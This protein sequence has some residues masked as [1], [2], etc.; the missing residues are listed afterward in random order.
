MGFV[1]SV[2]VARALGATGRGALA[3][4]GLV[5][6]MALAL[7]T[8]GLPTAYAFFSGK[9]PGDRD[10]WVAAAALSA[11]TIGVPLAVVVGVF[12][13][14]LID[15]W[16]Q[17][18]NTW[19]VWTSAAVIPFAFASFFLS[20]VF[21]G[22]GDVELIAK[23][24]AL[25]GI[26]MSAL[27]VLV[28]VTAEHVLD[29]LIVMALVFNAAMAVAYLLLA[30]RS[31]GF[32]AQGFC[33]AFRESITYG[34][35]A[36]LG[37]VSNQVWLRA[38]AL[39]LNWIAGPAPVGQYSV[40]TSFA[41]RLWLLDTSVG[42]AVT[43]SVIADDLDRAG[44]LA[45]RTARNL[46]LVS[47]SISMAVGVL[48]PFL[49]PLLY[50][51]EFGGAATALVC[52][53]PGT[54]AIAVSRPISTYY[55]GQLGRPGTT[56]AVS[57]LT[58][59]VA[60]TGYVLLIPRYAAIG[61]AV[62]SSIAYSVPL[63]VYC[64]MFP[65]TSGIPLS[66]MLLVQ[67]EDIGL[68]QRAVRGVWNSLRWSARGQG[69]RRDKPADADSPR[70]TTRNIPVG[71][72]KKPDARDLIVLNMARRSPD[73][74]PGTDIIMFTDLKRWAMS[75]AIIRRLF[76]Y[77]SVE[78]RT[79]LYP[80]LG[81]LLPTAMTLRVLTAGP[82]LITD[83]E[84]FQQRV[85]LGFLAG[86][87]WAFLRDVLSRG[88][89][90]RRLTRAVGKLE[91]SPPTRHL[92]LQGT[93]L[94]LRT[95]FAFGIISGGS[96]GHIAG[97]LNNLEHFGGRPVF[98][99]SDDI[100]TVSE[101][102]ESHVVRP[103]PRY[104]DLGELWL[105]S[106]NEPLLEEARSIAGSRT[107]S[108]V[109]QRYS[110]DNFVGLRVA[111]EFQ[112]PF[113]LEYNGS[114]VWI[115][116]N[117]GRPLK[118]EALAEEIELAN[119]HGADLVV[120]VSKAM[121]DELVGRGL[122]PARIL[123]NPNGVD[124]DVYSPEV[125]G[126]AVRQALG[127]DGK[128]VIGFIGTFGRWHGAEVLTEAY[129]LLL[130]KRPEFRDTSRLLMIGDG[131]TMPEVRSAIE[132]YGIRE[133]VVLT[134]LVPQT[135]G[136]AHLAACD[137]LA[138]PHVPNPDGTPFFG[139]PTKLF[140]YMAMGTGIVASDLDQIGEILEH[141]RTAWMVEPGSAQGLADGLEV[142]MSDRQ[143]RERLGAAA[144]AEVI[145]RYTWLEHTRRIIEALEARCAQ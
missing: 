12:G 15:T 129:G 46:L 45:A 38:D 8:F 31:Y 114:E 32:R 108:F 22:A 54:V 95:D 124:P 106:Y 13:S 26:C 90:R 143:L 141:G 78:M 16:L 94:Y 28:V 5:A 131:V 55:S 116:R 39:I 127:L 117:W 67:A 24:Q 101:H 47:G 144:R 80:T 135:Q 48:A 43:P 102:I 68:Y 76:R 133:Q 1:T 72:A 98:V 33:A 89:L 77:R 85:T 23:L 18:L 104:R 36:Y 49:I 136:P 20:N 113:V 35:K 21:L 87:M 145:S 27:T 103:S 63:A 92:E 14:S 120:V 75:G 57:L 115:A 66:R 123:V 84:G 11:M 50:G 6:Q 56:S 37:S 61:A 121:R 83:E 52:L 2:I 125:D 99:S 7:A 25:S 40:A 71:R 122:D 70:T 118:Y 17:G 96:L 9:R 119:L 10:V 126:W 30:G 110:L 60:V 34:L 65:R 97:V 134:G 81:R 74:T 69:I 139:S 73:P 107:L 59:V 128:T 29:G 44:A 132:R 100:S 79:Y 93:P 64:V 109:Y 112:V 130:G 19:Q 82:C 3:I 51:P 88:A 62:A 111:R 137:V 91:G 42:Q 41:E 58:M 4:S 53:L 142:L 105:A 86:L 138:S 140:E